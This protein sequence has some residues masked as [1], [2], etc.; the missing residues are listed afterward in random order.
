MRG[1]GWWHIS[2]GAMAFGSASV[3]LAGFMLFGSLVALTICV[4]L[5]YLL[6][7][8]CRGMVRKKIVQQ[9]CSP[10]LLAWATKMWP[11]HKVS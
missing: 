1:I 4:G 3:A 10:E 11:D 8:V 7:W 5:F 6:R 9:E 2:L